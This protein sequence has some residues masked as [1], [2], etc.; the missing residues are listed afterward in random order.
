M[1]YRVHG[2]AVNLGECTARWCRTNAE[3][4]GD[5]TEERQ[6]RRRGKRVANWP[7]RW[8][9]EEK[10]GSREWWKS[11]EW[12]KKSTLL[13]SRRHCVG[14]RVRYFIEANFPYKV[15]L[16]AFTFYLLD[17]HFNSLFFFSLYFSFALFDFFFSVSLCPLIWIWKFTRQTFRSSPS[18]AI[19]P[20]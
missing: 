16:T 8:R 3:E 7:M 10:A 6:A 18:S 2:Q 1:I 19:T 9:S 20:C 14:P 12:K 5:K 15:L 4:K 13:Q 17:R 11:G